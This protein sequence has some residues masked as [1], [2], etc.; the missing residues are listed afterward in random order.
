MN[1]QE[2]VIDIRQIP[3]RQRLQTIMETWEALEVGNTL[4]IINDHDP[5]HL[6]QLLNNE[7]PD[8]VEWHYIEQGPTEWV[9]DITKISK[10]SK[11]E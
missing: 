7:F 11:Q 3:I 1:P 6:Q 8:Q 4:R 5:V 2:T 9:V 10:N